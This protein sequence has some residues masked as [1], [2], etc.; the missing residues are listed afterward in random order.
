MKEENK[1]RW[2]LFLIFLVVLGSRLYFV[3]QTP[4]FN[5]EAYLD[6]RIITNIAETG[7]PFF[8]DSL[9]Y[10]GRDL[11]YSP[12][13]HYI[14]AFFNLLLPLN[15]VLKVIPSIFISLLVFVVYWL[16]SLLVK[17]KNLALFASLLSGFI[18]IIFINTLNNI[19]VYTLVLPLTF[20]LLYLLLKVKG[21]KDIWKFITLSFVLALLH[22]SAFFFLLTVLFFMILM[23]SEG[24]EVAKIKKELILFSVFV[25]LFIEFLIYKK[26]FIVHGIDIVRTNVPTQVLANYFDFSF[27]D[28]VLKIGILLIILGLSGIIFGWVRKREEI[29]LLGSLILSILILSGLKLIRLEVGLMFLGTALVIVS[30]VSFE[31]LLKYLDK[32]RLAKRKNL[33]IFSFVF[34]LIFSLVLP[35]FIGASK[36][37][38]YETPT[39]YEILV[40]NW[41]KENA[42]PDITILAPIEKGHLITAL[43]GKRNVIDSN[44]LLAPETSERYKDVNTIY[45]SR[46][47]VKALELIRKHN[48]DYIL[49]PI[50]TE[51]NTGKGS[52]LNDEGCFEGVFFGTPKV[53][54]V[55][56]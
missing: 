6:Y 32:T 12:V 38:D 8:Y 41:I 42:L 53:Y 51:L 4:Y 43:A 16:S 37:I 54:K 5:D 55:I 21:K 49:I 29:Y 45:T 17:E 18:P 19:S 22:P 36:N 35:S 13:F 52:W 26:A 10:N 56:C 46:S 30:C 23:V 20:Y 15:F 9:S 1:E 7:K 27:L 34:I 11:L 48:V 31:I 47:E 33:V 14:L 24:F 25:I 40:L 2:V 3:F 44:F 50:E 39:N 28:V